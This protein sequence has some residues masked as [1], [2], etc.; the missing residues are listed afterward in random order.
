[1]KNNEN[2]KVGVCSEMVTA[3]IKT[4]T[5]PSTENNTK[6]RIRRGPWNKYRRIGDSTTSNKKVQ[7]RIK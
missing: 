1:V 6:C 4:S 2:L 5:K 7:L 3:I